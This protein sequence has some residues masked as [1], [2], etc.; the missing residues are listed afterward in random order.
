MRTD[1]FVLLS[2]I[3]LHIVDDFVMQQTLA[4]M[5]QK[6]WWRKQEEYSD[7]YKYDWLVA[8]LAHAFE[9]TFMIMLPIALNY[10]AP[11]DL[12]FYLVFG[13]NLIVHAITDHCKANRKTIPLVV[14]QAIHLGQIIAT[15]VAFVS[16]L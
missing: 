13:G 7:M 2:M 10:G 12:G 9:W 1:G 14:D 16:A 3:F 11:L 8:L 6:A 4:K 5:K 15:Y